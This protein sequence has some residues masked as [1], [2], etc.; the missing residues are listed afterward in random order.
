[1]S[2]I[3]NERTKL[4]ATTL[5]SVAVAAIVAGFVTPLAA[6]AFGIPSTGGRGPTA[7]VAAALTFLVVGLGLHWLAIRLLGNLV[8]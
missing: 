8:E 6:F 4:R 5:N 3:R 2:L 1:M 7:T